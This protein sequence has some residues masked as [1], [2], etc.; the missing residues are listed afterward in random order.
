MICISDN[1]DG[2]SNEFTKIF[3]LLIFIENVQQDENIFKFPYI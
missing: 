3:D 2:E 1:P